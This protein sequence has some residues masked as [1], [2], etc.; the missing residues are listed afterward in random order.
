MAFMAAVLTAE[1]N[2]GQGAG[3][4]GTPRQD[5][6]AKVRDSSAGMGRNATDD[7]ILGLGDRT[8]TKARNFKVEDW[9]D[10]EEE[11]S[12]GRNEI[13]EK[14]DN[15][16]AGQAGKD[17][18]AEQGIDEPEQ[19][20]EAFEANPELKRAW[21]DAQAYK[22]LFAT[23]EEARTATRLL[24]D[25][26]AMDALFFSKRAED[27]VELARMV[28]KL[29]P[30]AFASLAKAMNRFPEEN[31]GPEGKEQQADAARDGATQA[32]R[33]AKERTD[34]RAED[35][36]ALANVQHEFLQGANAEA[37]KGV[38]AAIE[39]QVDRLLPEKASGGARNRVVSEIYRELDAS[40]QSNGQFA[41]QLRGALRSGDLDTRHH[42]AVVSLIVGRARQALPSVAKRVL[43]EWTSTILAASQ[44]RRARQRSAETRVDIGGSRGTGG[45]G[46]HARSPRDIDYG[47]MSDADILNL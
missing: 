30:G 6:A 10:G 9:P 26:N 21:Q 43:N 14:G 5:A 32:G 40:L 11:T 35:S 38:L 16:A 17:V 15:P 8:R 28:A 22:E 1:N 42:S 24:A 12:L 34:A 29:D 13:E 23:P 31:R 7:E 19:Y 27:H 2:I 37:V 47:R 46:H 25:V 45:E 39:S 33:T 36:A 20:R 18:E 4:S 44:D 3:N 41:K